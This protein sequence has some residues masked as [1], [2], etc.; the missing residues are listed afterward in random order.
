M[1]KNIRLSICIP[2]YNRAKNLR[3][4]LNSISIAINNIAKRE[5]VEICVSNNGSSDETEEIVKEAQLKMPINYSRNESNIGIPRNFVKVVNMA[6]G[7]FAWL[8]GDDD[9]ILPNTF[10][11]ILKLFDDFQQID[12]FFVNSYHLSTEFVFSFPQPFHTINLPRKMDHFST[13]RKSGVLPFLALIDPHISFDFLGGMFLAVFRRSK[14]LE[15]VDI[16]NQDALND[17]RLFSH[18]D[19]TFPHVK[20][21]ANAFATSSAYFNAVP[22]SVCLTGA[23]E[24][25]KLYPLIHSVRLVE[26]LEE[27]RKNGLSYWQYWKCRN[28][29]LNNFVSD[30]GSMILHKNSG[31][32]YLNLLNIIF[33]NLIYPNTYLSLFYY[34]IRKL[35]I[36][37]KLVSRKFY[38]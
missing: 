10:E 7:E 29:A 36:F 11:K 18:F 19:N 27:Y 16:L 20:I 35:S 2:T 9:L 6:S 17:T 21:F 33:N 25:S 34:I 13:Y 14:W 32:K 5:F 28:F 3:N 37:I 4:C 24:W 12:Y 26:A 31:L 38:T 8:I 23:R 1:H 15:K 22:L 30:L